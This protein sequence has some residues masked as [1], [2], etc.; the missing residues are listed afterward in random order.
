MSATRPAQSSAARDANSGSRKQ[1]ILLGSAIAFGRHG[2]RGTS[3][4]EIA[5]ASGVSLTLLSHH[6]GCKL[7]LLAS[8]V[9][10]HHQSCRHD[11]AQL[12]GRLLPV[13][14]A[15][16]V[17]ELV[18]AWL[19]HE[20]AHYGT[21]LGAHYLRFLVRLEDDPEVDGSVRA[22]LHATRP[23]AIGGLQRIFPRAAGLA[24]GECMRSCGDPRR[25]GA[26]GRR[27]AG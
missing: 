5:C 21:P 10:A 1:S 14:G 9:E 25:H 23:L 19:D 6:F 17:S 16:T 18:N 13:S 12:R 22:T 20:F 3:L 7:S 24:S 11:V 26:V 27:R 8:V 4:R 15:V 2:V